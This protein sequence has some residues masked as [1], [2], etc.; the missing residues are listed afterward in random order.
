MYEYKTEKEIWHKRILHEMNYAKIAIS[1]YDRG[2][3]ILEEIIPL[4][5]PSKQAQAM[6]LAALGRFMARSAETTLNTK[7]WFLAK[8]ERDYAALLRIG[9]EEIENTKATVPLVELDS[10]LGWEPTMEYRADRAHLEW[11][12][13]TTRKV[14]EEEIKPLMGDQK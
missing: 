10:R 5:H 6:R 13:E 11:K 3:E 2:A 14:M 8:R 1:H 4:I 12:I 7:R 9:E